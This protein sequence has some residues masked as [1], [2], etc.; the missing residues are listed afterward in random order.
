M[1][2][3]RY[4]KRGG[5]LYGPYFYKSIRTKDGKVKNIYL[6]SSYEQPD[7]DCGGAVG[8]RGSGGKGNVVQKNQGGFSK[9]AGIWLLVI[10][11]LLIGGLI[12][13]GLF[14]GLNS[15]TGLVAYEPIKGSLALEDA[16][17]QIIHA[18]QEYDVLINTERIREGNVLF[19]DNSGLFNITREGRINFKPRKE[20]I[21]IHSAA[22]IAKS[23]DD[24]KENYLKIIRFRV[25]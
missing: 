11:V 13:G 18:N 20:D 25:V 21:G 19:T 14:F 15:I 2:H 16:D 7:S 12:S 5:K 9:G 8:W 6:G 3:K 22:I 23:E 24:Y 10:I 17:E 1:V 4:I